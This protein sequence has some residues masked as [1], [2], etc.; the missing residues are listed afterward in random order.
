[1]GTFCKYD[2]IKLMSCADEIVCSDNLFVLRLYVCMDN[3]VVAKLASG[4]EL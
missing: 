2:S 4:E 1:M 3:V